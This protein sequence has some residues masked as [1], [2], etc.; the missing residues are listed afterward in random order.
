MVFV[1]KGLT[2]VLA[3][4]DRRLDLVPALVWGC[5]R[6]QIEVEYRTYLSAAAT[7]PG[8]GTVSPHVGLGSLGLSSC[9]ALV[10]PVRCQGLCMHPGS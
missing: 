8:L 9:E 4:N 1:S 5:C 2:S 6:G 3:G 7:I 10:G